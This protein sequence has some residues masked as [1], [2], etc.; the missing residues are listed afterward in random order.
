MCDST[1]MMRAVLWELCIRNNGRLQMLVEDRKDFIEMT[2]PEQ[3]LKENRMLSGYK[4]RES[5]AYVWGTTITL[6]LQEVRQ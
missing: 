1:V 5:L 6:A 4:T 2:T 3:D